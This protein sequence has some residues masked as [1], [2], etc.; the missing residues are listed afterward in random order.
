MIETPDPENL[1]YRSAE[2]LEQLEGVDA[3]PEGVKA[4]IEKKKQQLAELNQKRKEARKAYV[5]A[6]EALTEAE[7]ADAE[8]EDVDVQAAEQTYEQARQE[9]ERLEDLHEAKSERLTETIEQLEALHR[10]AVRKRQAKKAVDLNEQIGAKVDELTD[11]LETLAQVNTEMA[12]L[13]AEAR[14]VDLDPFREIPAPSAKARRG[15]ET[16]ALFL[17]ALD[18]KA[19]QHS[20]NLPSAPNLQALF[21]N[22]ESGSVQQWRG[23]ADDGLIDK[24]FG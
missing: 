1:S 23:D 14:S 16:P 6:R 11:A 3:D 17:K 21:R 7:L 5:Q 12:D 10:N 2:L 8:G 15:L 13:Q 18:N 4:T 22:L 24:L 9:K 20:S 19:D